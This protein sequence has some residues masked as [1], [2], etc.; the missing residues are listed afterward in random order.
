MLKLKLFIVAAFV[1]FASCVF[2]FPNSKI[3]AQTSEKVQNRDEILQ[4]VADYKD[5]KQVQKPENPKPELSDILK[6]DASTSASTID[7]LSISNS[8]PAG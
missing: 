8:S 7:V 4:K 6:T 2:L 5:W 1:A 3:E